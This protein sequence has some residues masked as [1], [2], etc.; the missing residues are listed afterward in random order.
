MVIIL[1]AQC[2]ILIK[3]QKPNLF[4]R[5][6]DV[7]CGVLIFAITNIG[8]EVGEHRTNTSLTL[9]TEKHRT[10]TKHAVKV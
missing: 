2:A 4:F 8:H 3:K 1:N 10:S 6:N 9:V 7:W 5:N